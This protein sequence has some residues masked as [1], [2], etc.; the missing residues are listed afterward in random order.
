MFNSNES[1][2]SLVKHELRGRL[3]WHNCQQLSTKGRDVY[4]VSKASGPRSVVRIP[5]LGFGTVKTP[6]QG[7]FHII[8][9]EKQKE[10][11]AAS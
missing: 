7:S 3:N 11:H 10:K 2:S 9:D 4:P 1:Y 8:N 5:E 6:K